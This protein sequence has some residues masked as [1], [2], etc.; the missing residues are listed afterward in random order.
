VSNEIGIAVPVHYAIGI[1]LTG[2]YIWAVSYAGRSPRNL[3]L[4]LAFGLSTSVL[5]WL[6][7]FPAMGY[8]IV[9]SHGPA[10]TRLFV[11]SLINHAL[12]GIGIWL[13]VMAAGIR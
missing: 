13:G 9:G 11:S 5:A 10:G 4:A 12:F 7:M 8:G 2:V 1:V 3:V 6:L